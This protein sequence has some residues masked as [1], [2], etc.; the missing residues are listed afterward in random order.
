MSKIV[1]AT[2]IQNEFLKVSV[3][4]KTGEIISIVK[5]GKNVLSAPAQ[6]VIRD[7]SVSKPLYTKDSRITI[8]TEEK[9]LNSRII[10]LERRY[11]SKYV[12]IEKITLCER[13]ILWDAELKTS[14][15]KDRQADISFVFPVTHNMEECFLP[16]DGFPARLEKDYNND[17]SYRSSI[18]IPFVI[19][20]NNDK[21][22]GISFV[23][24]FENPKPAL[25]FN[26]S[27][28]EENKH[29]KVSYNNF[30]LGQKK[31]VKTGLYVIMHE[32]DWRPGLAWMLKTYPQYF[33]SPSKKVMDGEGWFTLTGPWEKEE[34]IKKNSE[35]GVKWF[36]MHAHFPFYGLYL[37]DMKE[38]WYMSLGLAD[39]YKLKFEDWEKGKKIKAGTN[40]CEKMRKIIDTWRKYG[41]QTYVYYQCFEAWQPYAKKFFPKDRIVLEGGKYAKPGSEVWFNCNLMNPNP[42]S[43]WGKHLISQLDKMIQAY[44]EMGGIFYDRNDYY[45]YDYAHDDGITMIGRK[46]CSM[47]AF[48]HE[49]LREILSDKLRAKGMGLWANG[50]TSIEIAKT[51]DG[52]MVEAFMSWARR[53]QCMG[54]VK[55]II[56]LVYDTDEPTDPVLPHGTAEEKL[57]VS[58]ACGF[59]PSITAGGAFWQKIEKKYKPLLSFMKAKKW[60]LYPH[61]LV[62]PEET[63]GNIFQAENSDYLVTMVHLERTQTKKEPFFYNVPV[64]IRIPDAGYIKYCYL[65]SGDYVGVNSV[66]FSTEGE[67]ITVNIPAHLV[68]SMLILS[69]KPRFEIMRSSMPVFVSGRENC[70]ELKVENITAENK[71]Y[72]ISIKTAWGENKEKFDLIPGNS[73]TLTIKVNVPKDIVERETEFTVSCSGVEQTMSA[74]ITDKVELQGLSDVFVRFPEGE[75][76]ALNIA[77]NSSDKTVLDVSTEFFEGEG[78]LNSDKKLIIK[79]FGS[80]RLNFSLMPKTRQSKISL[81][82]KGSGVEIERDINILKAESKGKND[83][84][85]DDFVSGSMGKLRVCEGEFEVKNGMAK[86]KGKGHLALVGD[87]SW[88]DYEV[89]VSVKILGSQIPDIGWLK[90]YI[91]FR[92]QKNRKD[93]YRF[94]IHGDASALELVKF[95]NGN[96]EEM[97]KVSLKAE[98]NKWY[99]LMVRIENN[100]I[101]GYLDGKELINMADEIFSSGNVGIG[102]LENSMMVQYKDLIVRPLGGDVKK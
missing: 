42:E 41:V 88:K 39:A 101:K 74:Y 12:S 9:Q 102:V 50:P 71:S 1:R 94:G 47:I 51:A 15:G 38:K 40:S 92:V 4:G 82:V 27:K 11:G 19:V 49:K 21:D 59:L 36:E 81:R 33:Y 34:S 68:S 24:P 62:L 86:G 98:K 63:S 53:L 93:Y 43:K 54:M 58:L 61:A 66:K 32:G 95:V 17:F 16:A 28:T 77:N 48:E 56:C 23:S 52:M 18:F 44:P 22:V 37:P 3:S 89:Q 2:T 55:P 73:K 31:S 80:G 26:I 25:T 6:I 5:D 14:S 76:L 91:F 99:T 70:L 87:S 45:N 75:K 72:D 79:P 60:V 13:A 69:R 7:V 96:A 29:V 100:I 78:T 84:F 30:R 90:S 65:M 85:N 10:H 46:P 35:R 97:K 64:K 57:K 67:N 83:L 8:I 20:Y